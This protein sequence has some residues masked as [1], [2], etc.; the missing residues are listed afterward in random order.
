MSLFRVGERVMALPPLRG[1]SRFLTAREAF[2]VPGP[3][4]LG[5]VVAVVS[6]RPAVARV[7]FNGETVLLRAENAGFGHACGHV[8]QTT[9]GV[10]LLPCADPRCRAGV[11]GHDMYT[12]APPV[13]RMPISTFDPALPPR[14]VPRIHWTRARWINASLPAAFWFWEHA[15]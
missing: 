15:P 9:D 6:E 10:R 14:L 13:E 8:R 12:E 7:E 11:Q 2:C 3:G 5:R 4:R 1:V